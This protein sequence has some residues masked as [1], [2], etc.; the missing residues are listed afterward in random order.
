MNWSG[1]ANSFYPFFL[2]TSKF[3][4]NDTSHIVGYLNIWYGVLANK[5]FQL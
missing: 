1:N 2:Y 5:D 3:T 4:I